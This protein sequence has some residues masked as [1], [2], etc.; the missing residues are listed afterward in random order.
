MGAARKRPVGYC[1]HCE[2]PTTIL[3][4]RCGKLKCGSF[5]SALGGDADWKQCATCGVTGEVNG[6]RCAICKG[7]DWL[8][9]R[10]GTISA[11]IG[12]NF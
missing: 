11:K 6:V 4:A 2:E 3:N 8:L 7:H 9:I 12:R 10:D 5:R 1:A